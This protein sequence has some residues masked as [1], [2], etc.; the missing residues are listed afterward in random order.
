MEI[1]EAA[2]DTILVKMESNT[3]E[4]QSVLLQRFRE[5]QPIIISYLL[6]QSFDLL[7][8]REQDYMFYLTL[9]IWKVIEEKGLEKAIVAEKIGMAEERNWAIYNETSAKV[10]REKLDVFFDD[11]AEEDLLAFVEDAL[12]DEE[13]GVLTKEGRAFIFIGLKS[14]IDCFFHR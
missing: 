12:I 8:K 9:V 4:E 1:T 14:I 7:T 6:S 2:I 10:F 5:T 3:E 13:S 11:Y